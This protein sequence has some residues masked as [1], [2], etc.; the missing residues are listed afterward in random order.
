MQ[1][2]LRH[3]NSMARGWIRIRG[4]SPRGRPNQNFGFMTFLPPPSRPKPDPPGDGLLSICSRAC[5]N[6]R[7]DL[8]R[9]GLRPEERMKRGREDFLGEHAVSVKLSQSHVLSDFRTRD[10]K[11]TE[12]EMRLDY[13]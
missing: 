4:L 10:I 7:S 11:Q 6:C 8:P 5:A 13:I 2:N 3:E 1:R 9:S 12:L